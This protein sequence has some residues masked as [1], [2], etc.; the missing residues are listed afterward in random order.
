MENLLYGMRVLDLTRVLAGP[1]STMILAD[2]G[3]EVIKV[4]LPEV[5]DEARFFGPFQNGESAYFSSVNRGKKGI[6]IDLRTTQGSD[7]VR[8][9]LKDCDVLVENFRPGSMD[10]FGLG[11]DRLS[12]SHPHLV[13]ASISGFGQT[14]PYAKRPAYDVIIQAMGGI[15][16]ITGN[17]GESPVRVGSSIADLSAALFGAIGILAAWGSAKG[18]GLGQ[19]VDV[20]MLDCQMAMLEN[21]IARY[22]IEDSIPRPIGSRHPT[23]TPF[24]FFRASDGYIVLA[25]GNERLWNRLC[26]TLDANELLTDSRFV[27]NVSRSANQQDLER[28]LQEHFIRRSVEYWLENLGR[29]GIPCGPIQD[30]EQIC[31]DP[32]IAEREMLIEIEHPIAGLQKMPNSP[33]KFSRSKIELTT[34]SPTLGEHTEEILRSMLGIKE[35]EL[36]VLRSEKII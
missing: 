14:G 24:Q 19:H 2:L 29:E 36:D 10:R 26:C 9:L 1:Y 28:I 4:E 3:A 35:E 32:Q 31:N 18:T 11:Y 23:I 27:D 25:V 17:P 15:S 13:Y 30:I 33:L 7:I 20:S 8:R 22:Y 5:G 6:T 34:P 16:S 21:A 12:R